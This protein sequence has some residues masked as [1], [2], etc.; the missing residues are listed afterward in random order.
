[1]KK[2]VC[3]CL[4]GCLGLFVGMTY[5]DGA[6]WGDIDKPVSG[7]APAA[8]PTTVDPGNVA[9]GTYAAPG[10]YPGQGKPTPI[11]PEDINQLVTAKTPEELKSVCDTL[12]QQPVLTPEAMNNLRNQPGL[13]DNYKAALNNPENAN[14]LYKQFRAQYL[15]TKCVGTAAPTSTPVVTPTP[16]PTQPAAG[17]TTPKSNY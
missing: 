7:S 2:L 13:P 8:S 9:P 12:N 16:T 14:N 17:A 10:S 3:V 15:Q 11:K 5:A 1:M 6:L 4:V